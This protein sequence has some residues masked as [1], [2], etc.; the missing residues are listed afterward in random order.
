MTSVDLQ[1]HE[2]EKLG[3]R[4]WK[5]VFVAGMGFFTDAYDL[6][7]IGVVTA[8]LMPLWGLSIWQVAVLNGAALVAAAVG[9]ITLGWLSDRFGRKCIYGFEM[10]VLFFAA[11]GSAVSVSFTMLL[12]MRVIVGFAVGGDYPTSAIVSA[13]HANKKNRG[14]LVL[15]V[16]AMQAVGLIVGPLIASGLLSLHIPM[17]WVWRLLLGLGAIPAISVFM[18]RRKLAETPQFLASQKQEELKH[19]QRF[20]GSVAV[21]DLVRSK[22][23]KRRRAITFDPR[24]VFAKYKYV[25]FGTAMSWF[26]FDIAFYGNSVSSVLILKNLMPQ[27]TLVTK[28]LTTA[29]I[30]FVCALP[31]YILAA[32][33]VDTVGRRRMQILGFIMMAVCYLLMAILNAHFTW[34]IV[35]FGI[36]FFFVNFGPNATTFL[37]PSEVF[38]TSIRASAHGISAAAGK[39]GAFIGAFFMPVVLES[40]G[41]H[42]TFLIISGI[43]ILGVFSTLVLP[44]MKGKSLEL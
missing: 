20:A 32:K 35:F 37:I 36:S 1:A 9:A 12:I 42:G 25:L 2:N 13:E 15:M 34:F 27:A 28:T 30:F 17:E 7:I 22:P 44:E 39:A 33:Y 14:L 24:E 23:S 5:M 6:F 40:L 18:L 29:A 21:D 41:L 11:L 10:L 26:L 16:F 3:M 31:G 4:H 43:C 38:P 19:Q 8:I